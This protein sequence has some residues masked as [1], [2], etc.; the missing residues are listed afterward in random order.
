[1][2]SNGN[3][4]RVCQNTGKYWSLPVK[5]WKDLWLLAC[6]CTNST[7]S[8][9]RVRCDVHWLAGILNMSP[10]LRLPPYYRVG[11]TQSARTASSSSTAISELITTC[12]PANHH[13]RRCLCH[14]HDAIMY[15]AVIT[16]NV[17]H[18]CVHI[19]SAAV[20][21]DV[22]S[23]DCKLRLHRIWNMSCLTKL[24]T[25]APPS[26]CT[27]SSQQSCLMCSALIASY[28]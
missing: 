6:A 4:A 21:P 2:L 1:M 23:I 14:M 11:R 5:V 25:P 10:W 7:H 8:L 28:Y 18:S 22:F 17:V 24:V 13:G 3:P 27:Y 15:T 19:L 9:A 16:I 20:M 12:C 26:S